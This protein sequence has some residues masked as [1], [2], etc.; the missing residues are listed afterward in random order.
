MRLLSALQ[1]QLTAP[2]IV[3]S[4]LALAGAPTAYADIWSDVELQSNP[5]I[6]TIANGAG[7]PFA[8]D[9]FNGLEFRDQ[10]GEDE[11]EAGL[12][13]VRRSVAITSLANNN[14][15]DSTIKVG[16]YQYWYIPKSVVTGEHGV[17]G[18]GLP[19]YIDTDGNVVSSEAADELRKRGLL[20]RAST[21]VYVALNTCDRPSTNITGAEGLF[22]QL[23]VYYSTSSDLK[24]PG[25]GQ[26]DSL[27]NVTT[28]SQGYV[29]FELEADS[30]VYIS[31]VADNSTSYYGS[32]SY[33]LAISIDAYFYNVVP[34]DPFLY[35]VDSDQSAALLVTNNLTQSNSS[36]Q[37]YQE[38]MDLSPPPYTMYAHNLNDTSL[39]GMTSSFCAVQKHSQVV[40]N[41]GN[42]GMTSR[43]LG[44]RPKEQFYILGL[45]RS[46]TYVGILGMEGNGSTYGNGVVAG[47]GIVWQPMNFTTK[48]EDNC[49]VLFNLT[50]CSEVAY[51]VPA[52]PNRTVEDLRQIYD[53]YT[54]KY[55]TYFDYSLQQIQ[56]SAS[57]ESMFSLAVNCTDCATEYKQW[58]CSVSIPRCADFTS[59]AS[60]LQVRNAGQD[61]I[62]GSSLPED[63]P[64]RWS[65]I[66]N[67]SRNPIIDSEIKP[68]PYKEILPC[69]DIC[70]DMVKSCPAALGFGCP[71]GSWLNASYGY[72]DPNGDI[73]CS[74]LGAAYYL[75]LGARLG[76]WGSV[77]ML[78]VM[79]GIWLIW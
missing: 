41:Q 25:P 38:W 16:A 24:Y 63:D 73:T 51:A 49:A 1:C 75:N 55:Y 27:Q 2:V 9:S 61:F 58:L 4:L 26:D 42:T 12:D 59:N 56:C 19:E 68:G 29:G 65:V 22:P 39:S 53:N 35:F 33:D 18:K 46:S 14:F 52:N 21:T 48:T 74:Y 44:N 67:Q 76:M 43:G 54:S 62:N 3:T 60:Y 77:Y 13:L 30:D 64:L 78:V 23:K 50:F 36:S 5:N 15:Q 71:T 11:D 66:T 40:S 31:V 8:L 34:D 57:A 7:L 70:H 69:T 47:G 45:N 72:R 32:Y 28:A 17:A 79:W 6:E 10:E 37:N 20:K